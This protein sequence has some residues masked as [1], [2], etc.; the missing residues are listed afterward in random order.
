[1]KPDEK[2]ALNSAVLRNTGDDPLWM[3]FW[4]KRFGQS[5]NIDTSNV[6]QQLGVDV[7]SFT[8]LCLCRAPREDHFQDDIEVACNRTGAHPEM[9][10]RIIR[11]GWLMAA[12]DQLKKAKQDG[13]CPFCGA[14]DSLPLKEDAL[15]P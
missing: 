10:M 15:R 13:S 14:P 12:S 7:D 11:Q 6:A 3:G 8:L 9:L 5:E 1:M 4:L 2:Q